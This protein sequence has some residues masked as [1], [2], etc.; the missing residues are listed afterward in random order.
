MKGT[1]V[2][3][4][5]KLIISQFGIEK[6]EKIL[7]KTGFDFDHVFFIREDIEDNLVMQMINNSCDVLEMSISQ[8]FEAFAEYWIHFYS[9]EVYPSFVFS[10][11]KEFIANI[12]TIHNVMTENVP[13]AKPPVFEYNWKSGRELIM[14]YNSDRGLIDLAIPIIR[15]IGKKY[16]ENLSVDKIDNTHF[17][18]IFE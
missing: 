10:N 1:I 17:K 13:N 2:K 12:H 9:Q 16:N 11:A 18:I 3:A 4:A 15:E 8:L 7:V 14:T 5:E 6:W